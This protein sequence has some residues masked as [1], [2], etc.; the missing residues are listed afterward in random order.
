M[1]WFFITKAY[2]VINE[3]T[4]FL[5]SSDFNCNQIVTTH[6]LNYK[7][8]SSCNNCLAIEQVDK[9]IIFIYLFNVH[10]IC[11]GIKLSRIKS[12]PD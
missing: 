1:V 6:D 5:L 12:L 4:K 8:K 2:I 9:N 10:Y 3:N 11:S 7:L